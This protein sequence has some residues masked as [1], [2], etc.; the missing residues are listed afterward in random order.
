LEQQYTD[1]NLSEILHALEE[2]RNALGDFDIKLNEMA[3]IIS[4]YGS[5]KEQLKNPSPQQ[6][7][8]ESEQ[9]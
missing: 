2:Y 4:G 3:A 7:M 6:Q 1:K 5:L 9:N 8:D